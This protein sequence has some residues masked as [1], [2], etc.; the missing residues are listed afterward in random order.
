M[1][2]WLDCKKKILKLAD[3]EKKKTNLVT[4]IPYLVGPSCDLFDGEDK[5][6][7]D[8]DELLVLACIS[9]LSDGNFRS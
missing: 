2:L 9:I 7:S 6:F 8:A 3:F 1:D 5:C 4:L